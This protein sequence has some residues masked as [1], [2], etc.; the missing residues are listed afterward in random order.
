M[1]MELDVDKHEHRK[2]GHWWK[3][4]RGQVDDDNEIKTYTNSRLSPYPLND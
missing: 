3:T 4:R 2:L 1:K